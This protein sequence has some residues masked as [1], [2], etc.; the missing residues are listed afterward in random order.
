[1]GHAGAKRENQIVEF[2]IVA[3]QY[4]QFPGLFPHGWLASEKKNS[5]WIV[6]FRF[7]RHFP[8][9]H[10]MEDSAFFRH[11]AESVGEHRP[12]QQ[13]KPSPAQTITLEKQ[14]PCCFQA[15]SYFKSIAEF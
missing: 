14:Y 2:K 12:N 3:C 9:L 5:S 13:V 1:M 8:A 6:D 11:P 15:P 4:S 7:D 10:P